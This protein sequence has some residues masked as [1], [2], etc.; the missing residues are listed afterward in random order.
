MVYVQDIKTDDFTI[1]DIYSFNGTKIKR[2]LD[3]FTESR[4]AEREAEARRRKRTFKPKQYFVFNKE[5]PLL[6]QIKKQLQ[7]VKYIDY[8]AY[9]QYLKEYKSPSMGLLKTLTKKQGDRKNDIHSHEYYGLSQYL[10]LLLTDSFVV[11]DYLRQGEEPDTRK[12]TLLGRLEKQKNLLDVISSVAELLVGESV[13]VSLQGHIINALTQTNSKGR[14]NHLYNVKRLEETQKTVYEHKTKD[15]IVKVNGS[16]DI[17]TSKTL[18][19]A[20]MKIAHEVPLEVLAGK[21]K[22][23]I[24]ELNQYA[25]VNISADEYMDILGI[26]DK[27]DAYKLLNN[28]LQD[29]SELAISKKKSEQGFDFRT[30]LNR[31]RYAKGKGLLVFSNEAMMYFA[32]IQSRMYLV[33]MAIFQLDWPVAYQLA[34]WLTLQYEFTKGDKGKENGNRLKVETLIS[35][36]TEL[37]RLDEIKQKNYATNIRMPLE[38]ALD[39]LVERNILEYWQYT[40]AKG[41]ALTMAERDEIDISGWLSLYVEFSLKLPSQEKY[42]EASRKAKEKRQ[43]EYAKQKSKSTSHKDK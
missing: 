41:V 19:L 11:M 37:P 3:F 32:G 14:S 16:L 35:S 29:I 33:N 27:K 30:W 10:Y 15:L 12:I 25:T 13:G 28:T 23:T 36:L 34:N 38:K 6:P 1:G 26:K 7:E 42:I 9:I 8:K 39:L 18:M 24:E 31:A 2:A 17:H 43:R 21:K 40:K 4:N 22:I 5:K 20:V